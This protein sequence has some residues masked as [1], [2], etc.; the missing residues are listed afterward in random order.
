[1]EVV[2][3]HPG[4]GRVLPMIR[5]ISAG[6]VTFSRIHHRNWMVL[7]AQLDSVLVEVAIVWDPLL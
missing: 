1:M 7:H 3:S 5:R 4:G 6:T 2:I